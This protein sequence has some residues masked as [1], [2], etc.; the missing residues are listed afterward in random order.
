MMHGID[1]PSKKKN[2]WKKFLGEVC[3]LEIKENQIIYDYVCKFFYV[4]STSN[5]YRRLILYAEAALLVVVLLC[6]IYI[7]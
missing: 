5:M 1:G 3:L 4:I 6:V 2:T 7:C